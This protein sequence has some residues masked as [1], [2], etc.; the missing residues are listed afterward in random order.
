MTKPVPFGDEELFGLGELLQM[1]RLRGYSGRRVLQGPQG[2]AQLQ[3]QGGSFAAA[4]HGALQATLLDV[5]QWR[6]GAAV[7]QRAGPPTV[8]L[9]LFDV[10]SLLIQAVCALDERRARLAAGSAV[11]PGAPKH[12]GRLG[13]WLATRPWATGSGER[14]CRVPLAPP[15]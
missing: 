8:P 11:V 4:S 5:L 15:R 1:T 3:F 9:L 7:L 10:E 14:L 2:A 12:V 13:R 6:R